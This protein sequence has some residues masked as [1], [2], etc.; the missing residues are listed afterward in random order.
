MKLEGK[1]FQIIGKPHLESDSKVILK[2]K[3]GKP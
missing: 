1:M 3:L 2:R